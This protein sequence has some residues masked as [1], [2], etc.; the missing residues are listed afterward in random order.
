MLEMTKI[1]ELPAEKFYKGACSKCKSEYRAQQKDLF[2]ES[3]YRESYWTAK[4]QLTGCGK[5]VYFNQE[6]P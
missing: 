6:R 5:I 2:Y 4:C 3:D 1:G